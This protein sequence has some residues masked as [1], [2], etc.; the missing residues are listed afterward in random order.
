MYATEFDLEADEF[1]PL[2]K[3]DVRKSKEVVQVLS[4]LIILNYV[5]EYSQLTSKSYDSFHSFKKLQVKIAGC[6]TP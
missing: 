6:N 1:V 4:V 5:F 3:G 2:P